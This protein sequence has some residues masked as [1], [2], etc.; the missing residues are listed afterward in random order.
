MLF[1]E[2]PLVRVSPGRVA[3]RLRL[4]HVSNERPNATVDSLTL[5]EQGRPVLVLVSRP[6]EWVAL[7]LTGSLAR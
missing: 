6:A 4:M 3:G 1:A 5:R 7:V 2:K